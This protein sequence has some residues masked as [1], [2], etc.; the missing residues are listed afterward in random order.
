MEMAKAV[1]AA[2]GH[3]IDAA[4]R[5]CPY[6]GAD[7]RSGEKVV[8]TQ[9][10]LQEEFHP[11]KVSAA[12]GVL[13]YARQRQ[14]W[15]IAIA[16]LV[17]ILILAG[18]HEIVIQRNEKNVSDAP[19]VPLTDVTDLNSQSQETQ[20]LPMPDL[21]FQYDGNPQTMRTFIVEKGAAQPQQATTTA[22][23]PQPPR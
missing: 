13:E 22:P 11:R 1:C 6:C 14:G 17:L 12:E 5:L 4:A 21:Q 2:C 16:V 10:I 15:V 9:A 20:T 19:A 23:A 3:D 18:L 7:P 8:D